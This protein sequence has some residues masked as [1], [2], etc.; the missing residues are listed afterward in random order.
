MPVNHV[1]RF[2]KTRWMMGKNPTHR[3]TLPLGGVC[4]NRTSMVQSLG[5]AMFSTVSTKCSIRTEVSTNAQ[6]TVAS[7]PRCSRSIWPIRHQGNDR[8][9]RIPAVHC[10]VFE[11]FDSDPS[12]SV[13]TRMHGLEFGAASRLML[14]PWRSRLMV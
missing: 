3:Q 1:L 14:R 4:V 5:Y 10:S 2:A 6:F 9:L 13:P 11:G 8:Y 7:A 12:R